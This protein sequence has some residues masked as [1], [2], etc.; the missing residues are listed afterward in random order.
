MPKDPATEPNDS[1]GAREPSSTVRRAG[2]GSAHDAEPNRLLHALAL[3]DYE[4]LL[5][6]LSPMRLRLKQVLIEPD[7]PI[8]YVYFVRTGVCSVLATEQEGGDIEVGTTGNEGLVGL[9]IVFGDD[10]LPNR[11]IVQIEG[12]AWRIPA[13]TFGRVLE[14]RAA[15]RKVCLRF[16]AYFTGQISQSV[17]CNRLHTLEERA[18]RW[19]LMTHDRVHGEDFELTH[20]FLALMLG[21]RRAGVTVAM[22]ALQAAGVLQYKRGRVE[23]LDRARLEE[24]SCDCYR[25]TQRAFE[26]LLGPRRA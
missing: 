9:P 19:M 3:D 13:D 11:V 21:V 24:A 5:P 18:A 1:Y 12:D 14:H 4:W 10:T 8:P 7:V 2:A 16:A 23:V 22:G 25:I 17:A 6:Q 26:R 20:E 15:V